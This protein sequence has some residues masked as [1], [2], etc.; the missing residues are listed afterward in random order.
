MSVIAIKYC[1]YVQKILWNYVEIWD[2]KK[3]IKCLFI[4]V[5]SIFT[6]SSSSSSSAPVKVIISVWFV[7]CGSF[8][9]FIPQLKAGPTLSCERSSFSQREPLRWWRASA[10]EAEGPGRHLEALR[11]TDPCPV[12]AARFR[13]TRQSSERP[14]WGGGSTCCGTYLCVFFPHFHFIHFFN[15]FVNFCTFPFSVS[16]IFFF[17]LWIHVF[18]FLWF[19]IVPQTPQHITRNYDKPWLTNSKS[20]TPLKSSDSFES[21]GSSSEV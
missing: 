11:P 16:C 18:I 14:R 4:V 3:K 17:N 9:T 7:L 20:C 1:S 8:G 12:R 2:L 19:A 13:Q 10:T 21:Q 5:I 6:S 15:H